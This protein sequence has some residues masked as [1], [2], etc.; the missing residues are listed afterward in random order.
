MRIRYRYTRIYKA[1]RCAEFNVIP[2]GTPHTFPPWSLC[3]CL[4]MSVR[5]QW[6]FFV[7]QATL[8]F[9]VF[10]YS[11]VIYGC[12]TKTHQSHTDCVCVLVCWFAWC[13]WYSAHD[14]AI[15]DL[16][17]FLSLSVCIYILLTCH[18]IQHPVIAFP[19]WRNPILYKV[20]YWLSRVCLHFAYFTGIYI[21]YPSLK[22]IQL[23][24]CLLKL[25]IF[26]SLPCIHRKNRVAF[27]FFKELLLIFSVCLSNETN[28][29]PQLGWRWHF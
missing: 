8:G 14:M 29:C 9:A 10:F 19:H 18:N 12:N 7:C 11:Y 17:L 5:V 27:S 1:W 13:R 21:S 25:S 4:C 22:G 28:K 23:Q 15:W 26:P 24:C 3:V 6:M 20:T 16:Y 2:N